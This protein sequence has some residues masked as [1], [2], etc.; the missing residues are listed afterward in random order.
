M[1]ST[2]V[3]VCIPLVQITCTNK[4]NINRIK[5]FT[6]LTTPI[7][8]LKQQ[9]LIPK[10]SFEKT[11]FCISIFIIVFLLCIEHNCHD[12]QVVSAVSYLHSLGII[13]RDI[14]DENLILNER[15]HC[16]LIDF[17]AAAY[18]KPGK[19]FNKFF[20]TMEY[21]SPEVLLGNK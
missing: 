17:G 14:K 19:L 7:G 8:F 18:L 3:Y 6:F 15:F 12:F 13:H 9:N 1:F 5:E 20:G 2:P 4:R 16:K 21:C 10:K 11:D